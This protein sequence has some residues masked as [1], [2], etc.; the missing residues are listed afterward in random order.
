[1]SITQAFGQAER[2]H[3]L[4]NPNCVACRAPKQYESHDYEL[5]FY[6]PN[7]KLVLLTNAESELY[8]MDN[9]EEDTG[10]PRAD[11]FDALTKVVVL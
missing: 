2:K 1:M 11:L 10:I 5:T 8:A 4:E 7:W 9:A 3:R 6:G